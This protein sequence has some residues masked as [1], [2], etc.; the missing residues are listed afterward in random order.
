MAVLC[1]Q[2]VPSALTWILQRRTCRF[3]DV[4]SANGIPVCVA[5]NEDV[6]RIVES[7]QPVNELR[8]RDSG[9]KTV[10]IPVDYPIASDVHARMLEPNEVAA[11]DAA[12]ARL[13]RV[14]EDRMQQ[15]SS[16]HAVVGQPV[17]R[18]LDYRPGRAGYPG[19]LDIPRDPTTIFPIIPIYLFLSFA[20]TSL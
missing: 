3:C 15:P 12:H 19:G 18:R 10:S 8:R 13:D 11:N 7:V 14:I 4:G 17:W 20:Y 1:E 6:D 16:P 9:E 2:A 5:C